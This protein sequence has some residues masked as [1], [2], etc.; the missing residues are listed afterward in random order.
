[1]ILRVDSKGDGVDRPVCATA[2]CQIYTCS[3]TLLYPDKRPPQTRAEANVTSSTKNVSV[4]AWFDILKEGLDIMPD[5]EWYQCSVPTKQMLYDMYLD[6]CKLHKKSFE[7][8]SIE[9]FRKVWNR[10]FPNI[11]LRKYCRF[12]KCDFCVNWRAVYDDKSRSPIER[13]NAK[14]RLKQHTM[15]AH[16][17]ER[18]FYHAKRHTAMTEP[19]KCISLAMDG[20][21][22]M[23]QGFP[24][25]WRKAKKDGAA[26][27]LKFHTQ[28]VLVHGS[29]PFVFL[30]KEDV[31]GDP[32]FT[33]DTLYR[34]LRSEEERRCVCVC[35]CMCVCMCVCVCVWCVCGFSFSVFLS[36]QLL[37]TTTT[38]IYI[39]GVAIFLTFFTYNWTIVLGKT[40]TRMC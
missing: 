18:G 16:T 33:V 14:D 30:A 6:D 40:R 25:F 10:N 1:M 23:P 3:R 28:I 9:T 34:A 19:D 26:G 13:A 37:L 8:C 20:T 36:L 29:T 12:A 27:R 7:E 17:R 2:M 31:A 24:H 22:Q 32:N 35:V 11:K 4:C 5:E 39:T 38:K 15:W 21:A